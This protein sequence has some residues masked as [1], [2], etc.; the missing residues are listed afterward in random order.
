[1]R[2][3][4]PSWYDTFGTTKLKKENDIIDRENRGL[5]VA[6]FNQL[7]VTVHLIQTVYCCN[8]IKLKK[9]S[10]QSYATTLQKMIS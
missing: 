2:F 3:A 5:K 7:L 6:R 8:K 10:L 4:I 1:V 9:L